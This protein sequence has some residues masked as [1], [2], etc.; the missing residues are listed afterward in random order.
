MKQTARIENWYVIHGILFGQCY[1]HPKIPD[2]SNIQ[3]S[4]L[5][6]FSSDGKTAE[7]LNTIYSLGEKLGGIRN[8]HPSELD[9]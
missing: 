6:K 2:G 5:A 4:G 1:D 9:L 7:T 8:E 3:T